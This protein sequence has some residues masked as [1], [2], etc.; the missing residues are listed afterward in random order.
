MEIP[1]L[2]RFFI[3]LSGVFITGFLLYGVWRIY[4][5]L[6]GKRKPERQVMQSAS[7]PK[8]SAYKAPKFFYDS[9]RHEFYVHHE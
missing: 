8:Q 6:Y 5:Y 7:L 9:G 3:G 4:D 2:F 1:R